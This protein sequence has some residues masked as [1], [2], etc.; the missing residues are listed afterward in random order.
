MENI[1]LNNTPTSGRYNSFFDELIGVEG[2]LSTDTKDKG[3]Y[4]KGRFYGSIYGISARS[5]FDDFIK[6]YGAY[7]TGNKKEALRLARE[8][9]HKRFY[10]PL[11]DNI[12][13]ISLAYKIFDTGVNT[14][15]RFAVKVLQ[16]RLIRLGG[17]LDYDGSFGA[18]TLH[19]V[20]EFSTKKFLTTK[21]Y[22]EESDLY[23]A[24]I[25]DLKKAYESFITY[26]MHGK[27]W[28]RRILNVFN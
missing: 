25:L 4:Y 27:G 10:N 18:I 26:P 28:I 1:E 17:N 24:Y 22:S 16:R 23:N 9:Y 6:V 20:N 14:G 19:Y 2:K 15:I 12:S 8:F 21:T 7:I 3:N 13:D 11:Y 5:F